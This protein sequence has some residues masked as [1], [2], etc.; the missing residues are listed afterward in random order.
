ME[1][2]LAAAT[3][4]G[5]PAGATVLVPVGSIEQHGPHLPLDTDTVIAT[6]V[7]TEAARLLALRDHDVLVAPA[8]SYGSS[9]E[10][11][12]FAG[13]SSIGTDV[14]HQV[15]V[16]L[17]R[18]MRT[19]AARVVLVNAHGGNLTALRGAVRQLTDEGHDVSWVACATEDVDLHAGRTETSLMLHLAPWNVRVDRAEA[20]NTGTIE[21]LLPAMIAGGV[22]AVSPNG[23]LGDPAGASAEEGAVVLAS[24]VGDVVRAVGGA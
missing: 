8:L 9:G 24:M 16:E 12:D 14:L 20:G 11:Q 17:T 23:V 10:H 5:L 2:A 15:V 18:S 19:W 21:E 22:K 4:P 3:S 6:A 13:T 7:A 1:R